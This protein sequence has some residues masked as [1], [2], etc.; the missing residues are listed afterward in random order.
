MKRT[1]NETT[2]KVFTVLFLSGGLP[3]DCRICCSAIASC[4]QVFRPSTECLGRRHRKAEGIGQ[5]PDDVEGETHCK[6]V[7]Y[8][9][10]RSSSRN[11]SPHVIGIDRMLSCKLAQHVQSRP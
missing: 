4:E 3:G 6:G 11:H 5:A 9:L 1:L 10:G 7:F 8:L 2:R